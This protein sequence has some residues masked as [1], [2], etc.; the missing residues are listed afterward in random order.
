MAAGAALAPGASAGEVFGLIRGGL[1]ETRADLGRLTGLSRTAVTLRVDQLIERGLVVETAAG[2]STGGRPPSRLVFNA[3][4][5]VVLAAA[6][7]ASRSQL[8]VCDLSGRA[9][10]TA[11]VEWADDPAV[12]LAEVAAAFDRLLAG[13][14]ALRG[15]GVSVPGT[16]ESG[17]S[18]SVS[19]SAWVDVDITAF[20]ADRY[21]VPVRVDNDV[22]AL[23]LAEHRAHP[24]ID[25]LLVI[26]VS[27]GIGAGIISGG[28]LRRGA[29]GAAGEIGHTK[30]A[31]G[32]GA[33]CRCGGVDCLEAVAGGWALVRE[34][35]T[36]G[37][38]V[39]T[40]LDVADL[41]RADDPEALRLVRA[42]GRHLGGVVAAAVNLLNPAMI[43]V[44]G[45]LAR[46]YEPLVA[47][48]REL[49]Y[50][51][52]AAAATRDLRIEPGTL[53]DG[54][55]RTGC[56]VMVLDDVLSAASVNAAV[57]GRPVTVG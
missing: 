13:R 48:M 50:Q 14:G 20:F 31:G 22:N 18:R 8:A 34:L 52:A 11:T 35:T 55:T 28:A 27:T 39:G 16:V 43:I 1:A 38:D 23:A 32:G 15:I 26:K 53:T 5:G 49:I 40:A 46:A 44:G 2:G 45:D 7:G 54:G 47:G 42:A 10:A 29:M 9:L 17:T 21:A 41:A 12:V 19:P 3:D 33:V 6:L 24:E 4:G 30:V 37:R 51:S 25:D 56:A 57:A 36:L